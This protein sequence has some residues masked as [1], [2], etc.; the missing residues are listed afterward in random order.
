LLRGKTGAP[1]IDARH[2]RSRLSQL[3]PGQIADFEVA[4]RLQSPAGRRFL[5]A[6]IP[7]RA[8]QS[9]YATHSSPSRNHA[10]RPEQMGPG[11][12]ISPLPPRLT[13]SL[14]RDRN[15]TTESLSDHAKIFQ[16]ASG[17]LRQ[18]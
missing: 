11:A 9:R 1:R 4:R 18:Q 8:A 7:Q 5:T 17:T 14:A 2:F 15:F 12:L 10:Q 3:Y 6:K 13:L 16:S